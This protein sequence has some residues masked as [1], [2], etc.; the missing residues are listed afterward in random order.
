M[1]SIITHLCIYT[2]CEET[3]SNNHWTINRSR[4][5]ISFAD[6]Y[7]LNWHLYPNLLRTVDSCDLT[8][9]SR[10]SPFKEKTHFFLTNC[11]TYRSTNPKSPNS[12]AIIE[13]NLQSSIEFETRIYN[14]QKKK[15][16]DLVKIQKSNPMPSI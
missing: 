8:K 3:R 2:E 5:K 1:H 13:T 16:K 15:N 9:A 7:M 6:L 10:N 14:F 11:R 12:I 4:S